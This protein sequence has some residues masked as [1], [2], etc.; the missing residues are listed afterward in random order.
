MSDPLKYFLDKFHEIWRDGKDARVTVECHAGQA[1]L[2]IHHRLPCP[3][4]SAQ[5]TSGCRR[6]SPSRLRRRARRAHAR[7][8][9][10]QATSPSASEDAASV[11][12][13]PSEQTDRAVQTEKTKTVDTTMQV[14]SQEE[15]QLPPAPTEGIHDQHHHHCQAPTA[16]QAVV[17]R[18][19]IVNVRNEFYKK[20]V[21]SY[22]S[23]KIPQLDGNISP[24]LSQCNLC[25]K[26]LE[27]SDDYKWHFE[28][29]HGR[30]DCRLLRS[31][32]TS[33]IF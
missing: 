12:I 9:A 4:P 30:E 15:H 24:K 11:E 18:Q 13:I 20:P 32:M 7:A 2:S 16:V 6:P 17:S 29:E 5:P 14:D 26:V 23:P 33:S 8:V 21:H 25:K 27:T 1:W 28:T 22:S 3:P 31:M 19:A 10:A